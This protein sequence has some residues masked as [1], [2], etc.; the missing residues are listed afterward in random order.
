MDMPCSLS[1]SFYPQIPGYIPLFPD[2]SFPKLQKW[3]EIPV[4]RNGLKAR[5]K[6]SRG[7]L[8]APRNCKELFKGMV[9]CLSPVRWVSIQAGQQGTALTSGTC[10][11]PFDLQGTY[12]ILFDLP[13]QLF[14]CNTDL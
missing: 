13:H 6:V 8:F 10:L 5:L 12:L 4:G 11:I 9:S 2:S 1:P 3:L 7:P 14:C